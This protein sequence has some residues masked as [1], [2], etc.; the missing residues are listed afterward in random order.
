MKAPP[1]GTIQRVAASIDGILMADQAIRDHY[2]IDEI[3]QRIPEERGEFFAGFLPWA[4]DIGDWKRSARQAFAAPG[5][6][7]LLRTIWDNPEDREARV[8]IDVM[9]CESASDAVEALADRLE[10]NQLAEIPEGP[11]SLGLASF[12]H[13]PSAPPAL[14]YVHGNLAITVTSFGRKPVDVSNIASR[15]DL[16][17]GERPIPEVPLLR[18]YPLLQVTSSAKSGDDV[19]VGLNLPTRKREDSYLKVF[20]TGGTIARRKGQLVTR[21]TATGQI[22]IEAFLIEPGAEALAAASTVIVR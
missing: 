14:F 1:L 21:S 9:E 7:L 5:D 11:R 6:R 10:A 19:V 18:V 12:R 16:K 4:E 13:P 20:V 22:E 3:L 8:L 15:L 2:R 17:L